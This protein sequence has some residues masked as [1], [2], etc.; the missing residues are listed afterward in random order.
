[1]AFEVIVLGVGDAFSAEHYPACLL[2]SCDDFYLGID[3][4][5]RY[6]AVLREATVKCGRMIDLPEINDFVITHVH[7]DHM[8]GLEAVGFYKYF[9]EKKRLRI[10]STQEVRSDLW[11]SRL[12]GS[13]GTLLYDNNRKSMDFNDYFEFANLRFGVINQLGPYKITIRQTTHHVPTFALKVEAMGRSFAYSS[14]TAFDP[15]LIMFLSDADLLIHET[16]L[17]PAHTSYEAL[18]ALPKEVKQRMRLIHYPDG[19]NKNDLEI[20]ALKEGEVLHVGA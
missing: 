14:D 10:H 13:M 8:N 7:G 2:L 16:N 11:D 9:V 6:A 18:T 15:E 1:M 17:G 20:P 12:R 19:L 5:D 3:C 4:P